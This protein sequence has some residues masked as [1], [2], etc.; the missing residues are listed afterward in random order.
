MELSPREIALHAAQLY[1]EERNTYLDS[2]CDRDSDIR[3]QVLTILELQESQ[4]LEFSHDDDPSNT[5]SDLIL[6]SGEWF[7]NFK[8]QGMLGRGA[9]GTVYL[10]EQ[11]NPKRPIALKIM[12]A[13]RMT[14]T[15]LRSGPSSS[16]VFE[17]TGSLAGTRPTKPRFDP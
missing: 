14:E 16:S 12:N 3:R 7:G 17:K 11:Q 10:A 5:E 8:I 13:E 4:T 1:G 6:E 15:R 9:M 2:A